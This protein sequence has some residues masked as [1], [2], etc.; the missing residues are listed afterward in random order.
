MEN[1]LLSLKEYTRIAKKII[2]RYFAITGKRPRGFDYDMAVSDL[3]YVLIKSDLSYNK[4]HPKAKTIQTWRTFNCIRAMHRF[5][6]KSTN[7][8]RL[9]QNYTQWAKENK[10]GYY[11]ENFNLKEDCKQINFLVNNSGLTPCQRE[12][13]EMALQDKSYNEMAKQV[14]HS[15]ENSVM[16]MQS[17]IEKMKKVARHGG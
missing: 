6:M 16:I 7:Y 10:K 12:H 1:Q 15:T 4:D 5:L 13:V 3:V 14:G 2:M 9:K 17:A 8:N 11:Y